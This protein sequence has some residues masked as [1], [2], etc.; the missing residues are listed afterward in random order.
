MREWRLEGRV[1]IST[2]IINGKFV[3][4][5]RDGERR[6]GEDENDI[7]KTASFFFKVR[8]KDQKE[9]TGRNP[10]KCNWKKI[11]EKDYMR[12]QLC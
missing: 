4:W 2:R 8:T 12:N 1:R 5:R 3:T 11:N 10:K 6:I 9:R 7:I